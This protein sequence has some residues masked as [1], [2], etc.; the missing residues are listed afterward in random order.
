VAEDGTSPVS[1]N[2]FDDQEAAALALQLP[3]NCLVLINTLMLQ[4]IPADSTWPARMTPKDPRALSPLPFARVNPYGTF[5][6]DLHERLALDALEV[7][8]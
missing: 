6:L 4:C 1:T 2:H 3:Q 7:A 5:R 8:G